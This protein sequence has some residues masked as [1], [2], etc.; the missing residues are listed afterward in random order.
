MESIT[1][2]WRVWKGAIQFMR[3]EE[4]VEQGA[5]D[6]EG[7]KDEAQSLFGA[8]DGLLVSITNAAN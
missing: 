5:E 1:N 2:C 4:I 3:S 8:V 6:R 7:H